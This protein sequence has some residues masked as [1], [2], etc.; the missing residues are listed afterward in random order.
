VSGSGISW[1]ICKSATR[2]RQ[3]T[4]P[5]PTTPAL[6]AAEPTASKH[7]RHI[8]KDIFIERRWM[9]IVWIIF[10]EPLFAGLLIGCLRFNSIF[11][12]NPVISCPQES[13]VVFL[14]C[15]FSFITLLP[16]VLVNMCYYYIHIDIITN[17]GF[18]FEVNYY[19]YYLLLHHKVAR[20]I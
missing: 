18:V 15:S 1:A 16:C 4:I 7:W 11:K 5:A 17:V 12:A 2:S 9:C 19:Y 3:I 8:S 14:F 13:N 6:P 10:T 20:T